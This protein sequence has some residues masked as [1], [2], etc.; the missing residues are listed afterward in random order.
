MRDLLDE[1]MTNIDSEFKKSMMSIRQL[2]ASQMFT[3]EQKQLLLKMILDDLNIMVT[4]V[5]KLL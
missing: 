3:P 5:R 1:T 2:S 4:E